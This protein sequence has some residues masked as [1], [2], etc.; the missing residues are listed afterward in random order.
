DEAHDLRS[1]PIRKSDEADFSFIAQLAHRRQRVVEVTVV[2]AEIAMMKVVEVQNVGAHQA[3][4]ALA[5]RSNEL[6]VVEMTGRTLDPSEFRRE[7]DLC[8]RDLR[9]N[10]PNQ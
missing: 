8:P 2:R 5:L 4:R 10:A 1:V 6:R 9:E 3:Q 7:K